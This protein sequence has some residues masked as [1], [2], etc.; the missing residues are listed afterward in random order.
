MN[1]VYRLIFVCMLTISVAVGVAVG[2]RITNNLKQDSESL[3]I[4]AYEKGHLKAD[5][6]CNNKDCLKS[7]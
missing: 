4:Q 1:G 2:A 5:A 6:L 7:H 3:R